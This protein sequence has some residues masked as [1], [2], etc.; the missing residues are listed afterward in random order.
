VLASPLGIRSRASDRVPFGTGRRAREIAELTAA[1]EHFVLY[2]PATFDALGA[3]LA[4]LDAF[5]GAAQIAA[6]DQVLSERIPAL[7]PVAREILLGLG[8]Y[9]ALEQAARQAPPGPVLRLRVHTWFNALRSL[10]FVHG[11]RQ[12]SLPSL[13]W[14]EALGSAPFLRDPFAD[15]L[16]PSAACRALSLAEAALPP[17][18]GP[19]LL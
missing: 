16:E 9:A 8:L 14:R 3:V 17:Q 2:A 15:G 1:G 18:V 7:A 13:P 11:L 5:A 10:R 4:G 19:T 6:V 12:R